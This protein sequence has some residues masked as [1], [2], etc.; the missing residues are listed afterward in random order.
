MAK[1]KVLVTRRWPEAVEQQLGELFDARLNAEDRPMSAVELQEALQSA[2]GLLCTVTDEITAEIL[3]VEPKRVK[4]LG[5]FG[6][7]FDNIDTEAAK[8][9]GLVVTNTPE[10]LTECTA[11]IAMTLLLMVA[12][13]TGEG[14]RHLRNGEWT[15]WRP[16]HMLGAKI[17]GKIL[18]IIGMGRIAKAIAKRAHH[19]FGMK[20]IYYDPYL[21]S[22]EEAKA[23]GGEPRD[24]LEDVLG[25]ADFVSLHCPATAETR[26][27][28]NS[29]RLKLMKPSAFLINTARGNVVDEAAL[30]A[31]LKEGVIAGA[32]LDVYEHEPEASKNLIEIENVVLLPHLGSASKETREAMGFRVLENVKTFFEGKEPP[33]RVA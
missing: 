16:T 17:S 22:H 31:A 3:S 26:H 7:G 18:G 25:E 21:S 29:Q 6:V 9:H 27:L 14:E 24:S 4:I 28:I 30:A 1:P 13:R 5:N 15:G 8:R 20:I 32:G 19:G 11:D 23:V 33:D 2:D 12:R 10:V